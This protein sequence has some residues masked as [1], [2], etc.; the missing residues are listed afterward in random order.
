MSKHHHYLPNQSG[1]YHTSSKKSHLDHHDADVIMVMPSH[2]ATN[3]LRPNGIVNGD[4]DSNDTNN[5][6][7]KHHTHH[8]RSAGGSGGGAEASSSKRTKLSMPSDKSG[9]VESS[10]S[11]SSTR[12]QQS[13][14]NI[15][16]KLK[17]LY[18]ELKG[19]KSCKEV[20]RLACFDSS[21]NVHDFVVISAQFVAIVVSTR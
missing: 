13:H 9:K 8:K 16:E 2:H 12:N 17:E 20:S 1:N 5:N 14:Y 4:T 6:H 19:D 7:N 3:G 15:M 10:S 11:G 18:K 21:S